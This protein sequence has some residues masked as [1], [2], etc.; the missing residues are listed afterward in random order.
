[1]LFG[2]HGTAVSNIFKDSIV[3]LAI[4]EHAVFLAKQE[5]DCQLS[6]TV[7][8]AIQGRRM[9]FDYNKIE[10][11]QPKD[12]VPKVLTYSGY[13]CTDSAKVLVSQIPGG[14][15][16]CISPAYGGKASDTQI[17]KQSKLLGKFIPHVESVTA[18]KGFLIRK[19]CKE[20]NIK[21]IRSPMLME[22]QLT[23][24]EAVRTQSI[25]RTRVHVERAI[26]RMKL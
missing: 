22:K 15:I 1:M 10:I 23:V 24:E 21:M 12:I 2:A 20:N 14:L 26:E 5:C 6:Y 11:K 3:T 8:Q 18:D 7:V 17:T 9:V 13:K 25:A 16:S 19:L 4:P